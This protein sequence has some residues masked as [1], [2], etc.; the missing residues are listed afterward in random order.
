MQQCDDTRQEDSEFV[1]QGTDD[2]LL[3]ALILFN[4]PDP[5]QVGQPLNWATPLPVSTHSPLD[6]HARL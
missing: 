1:G 6:L 4:I 2:V 3:N 5:G